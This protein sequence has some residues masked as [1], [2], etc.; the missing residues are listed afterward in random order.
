[1]A[2]QPFANRWYTLLRFHGAPSNLTAV[3]Q[4]TTPAAARDLQVDWS[5]QWPTETTLVFA[6]DNTPLRPA[7]LAQLAEP[8]LAE[9]PPPAAPAVARWRRSGS[10][11]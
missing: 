10:V 1:M 7:Q 9:S 3:A 8:P 6:P 2:Q 4:M 5:L 11:W